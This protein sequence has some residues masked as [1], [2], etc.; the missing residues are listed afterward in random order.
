MD[1]GLALIVGLGNPGQSYADTRH[2]AGFR[3]VSAL[4][5]RTGADFKHEN[6][7]QG[8]CAKVTFAGRELWL[9]M[10]MTYMNHSG[11]SVAALARFYKI[12]PQAILVAHDEL[13][14][15]PG[16]ARLKLGG[17]HGGHNG[18]RDIN[19]KMGTREF[20]RLRLGI[21][22]PGHSSQVTSYVLKKA[23]TAEQELL[24]AAIDM[25]LGHIDDMVHGQYQQVMN[26]LHTHT[27]HTN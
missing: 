13:D 20:V 2:N 15:A 16:T 10:P 7:F 11:E 18:L 27:L 17:G 26:L 5:A 3:F 19:E 1:Q 25:A 6:R 4:A 24:D 14:L 22:H 12:P 8:E 21:G 9:L 23:P